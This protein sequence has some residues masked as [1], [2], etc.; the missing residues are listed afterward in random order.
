MN[1]QSSLT[2]LKARGDLLDTGL[3]LAPFSTFN[4]QHSNVE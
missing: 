1:M 2:F 4:I 3:K